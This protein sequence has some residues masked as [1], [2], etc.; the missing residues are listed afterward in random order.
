MDALILAG[1]K[2]SRMGG[3]HKGSLSM[4]A[5]TFTAHLVSQLRPLADKL[6]LSYGETVQQEIDGCI[7][8]RDEYIDC[9]P[10]GGLHAG[11]KACSSEILL[12][13]ACD[14]PLLKRDLYDHLMELLPGYDGVVPV[15]YGQMHPLAAIYTKALLP[16]IEQAL[17]DGNFRLRT[18][19]EQANIRYVDVPQFRVMLNNINTREEYQAFLKQYH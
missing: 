12:V 3:E 5:E 4:G 13:A 14:M 19:L 8:V 10:M 2:S 15:T 18:A 1:G 17:K 11:L 7:I 16:I 9:G 6:W